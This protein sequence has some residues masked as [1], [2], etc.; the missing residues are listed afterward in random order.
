MCVA[1]IRDKHEDEVL[2]IAFG[3][4][5]RRARFVAT[6]RSQICRIHRRWPRA[7]R[8]EQA[9][10]LQPVRDQVPGS[11]GPV[12]DLREELASRLDLDSHGSDG[13]YGVWSVYYD[14]PRLRFYWEKIEGLR[15]RRK[16]RIRH[17][18][19]RFTVDDD[20]TVFVE[21]KQRVN[22]VTQKRRVA[23][24]YR[25]ALATVRRAAMPEEHDAGPGAFVEE[26]LE[27]VAG[28]D[29]RPVVDDRLP[30]GG[31]R[32]P[33]R[34]RRACGSPSTTGS[35]AATGTSTS[36]AEAENRLIVPATAVGGGG[37][38]QRAGA[39]LAHRPGRQ[40]QPVG[41]P[42]LEV[43]PERRGLRPSP[44]VGLPR[45]R[46]RP[47]RRLARVGT[48]TN[49]GLNQCPSTSRTCPARSASATSLSSLSLSFVLSATIGWVY[50]AT[51]RNVSYSQ[52]YVQTLVI[53]GM[54]ISLIMLV[55][56][57][58]IARAFALVGALSV[59]RFRNA[60]KE[61]RD[62]GFIFLVMGVGMACG[63]RFYTLAV[64][65]AVAI[66][67]VIVVMYRFNWF[68]PQRAA[69]GRQGP[70]ARR[71]ATTPRRSRTS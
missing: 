37:Q 4:R 44:S 32:R 52:S 21:I 19:D 7:A 35:A 41:R 12:A 61:T 23:L 26:V 53:L 11:T 64:V 66:C 25:Q 31:V 46:P 8:A 43:L 63:T 24:P 49:G 62:V 59:V 70:G 57:S 1:Q 45:P 13:G 22:R 15:F 68:A 51:H 27:L 5:W 9:A 69:A 30:A 71:T 38:G 47:R 55:V 39:V 18:G 28:L 2:G 56:G 65:A 29:L 48:G 42:G 33:R 34:R 14:T 3:E 60:I 6:R 50:R 17:Y 16:L 20:T 54:L 36:G 40:A 58:N 10:R 67:L